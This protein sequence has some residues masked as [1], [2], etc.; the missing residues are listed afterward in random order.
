MVEILN[1]LT[2]G[3]FAKIV[4]A[5]DDNETLAGLIQREADVTKVAAGDVL[6]LGQSASGPDAD[7]GTPGVKLAIQSFDGFRRLLRGERDID[8]REDATGQRQ[9]VR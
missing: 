7:H 3:A 9:E 8:G 5:R 4:E 6:Q 2:G 1:G